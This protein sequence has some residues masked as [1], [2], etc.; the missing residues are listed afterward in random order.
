MKFE[1]RDI[2]LAGAP[3]R[4]QVFVV[5]KLRPERPKNCYDAVDPVSGKAYKLG[6]DGMTKIGTADDGWMEEGEDKRFDP[7][8]KAFLDGKRRADM[9]VKY[10]LNDSEAHQRWKILAELRPG[11]EL[12]IRRPGGVI[13]TAQFL[14]V[15][16]QGQ[17]YAFAATLG[18]GR[19]MKFQLVSV[20]IPTAAQV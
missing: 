20:A 9:E 2:L 3:Y 8:S 15:L 10:A 12:K 1:E 6:D 7:N 11:D 4:P 5:T 17:K 18:S 16:A 14:Y 13:Q 19:G